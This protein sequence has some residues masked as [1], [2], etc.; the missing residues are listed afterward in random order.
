MTQSRKIV[1]EFGGVLIDSEPVLKTRNEFPVVFTDVS[2]SISPDTGAVTIEGGLG[3]QG[4]ICVGDSIIALGGI[5]MVNKTISNLGPPQDAHDAISLDFFNSNSG[6]IVAGVGITKNMNVISVSPSQLHISSLGTIRNGTWM[7]DPIQ[8]QYGG[9]GSTV[10]PNGQILFGSGINPVQTDP[11]FTFSNITKTLALGG[12]NETSGIGTGAL[13]IAGGVSVNK[14]I[15]VGGSLTV[16]GTQTISGRLVVANVTNVGEGPSGQGALDVAGGVTISGNISVEG[17]SLVKGALTLDHLLCVSTAESN[18]SLTG[19][20]VFRGGVGI[21]GQ[22]QGGSHATF[23]GRL[24]VQSIDDAALKVAGGAYFAKSLDIQG[25]IESVGNVRSETVETRAISDRSLVSAGGLYVTR[26]AEIGQDINVGQ[27]ATVSRNLKVSSTVRSN[28]IIVSSNEDEA[29][30]IAGGSVFQGIVSFSKAVTL[31]DTLI[32]IHTGDSDSASTGSVVFKGGLGIAKSIWVGANI[33]VQ[34]G[35]IIHGSTDTDATLSTVPTTADNASIRTAG[36]VTVKKSVSVGANLMVQGVISCLDVTDSPLPNLGSVLCAGGVGIAKGL[37]VGGSTLFVGASQF[38]GVVRF[39]KSVNIDGN[40]DSTSLGM[41]SLVTQGGASV[42]RSLQVGGNATINGTTNLIGVATLSNLVLAGKLTSTSLSDATAVDKAA[43]VFSGGIAVGKTLIVGGDLKV[44]GETNLTNV[45]FSGATAFPSVLRAQAPD[46]ATDATNGGLVVTGGIGVGKTL[47]VAGPGVFA[48]NVRV[49]GNMNV[50]STSDAVDLSSGCLQLDGGISVKR[51]MIIGG[52]ANVQGKLTAAQLA[53]VGGTVVSGSFSALGPFSSNGDFSSTGAISS[54]GVESDG[55]T[56]VMKVTQGKVTISGGSTTEFSNVLDSNDPGS[57]S[58]IANGGIGIAKSLNV[59]ESA[60]IHGTADVH[61]SMTSHSS[62]KVMGNILAMQSLTITGMLTA[63]NVTFTGDLQLTTG[64]AQ[65]KKILITDTSDVSGPTGASTRLLG[66]INIAKSALIGN[67]CKVMGA[68]RADTTCVLGGATRVEGIL[69]TSDLTES[70]SLS[71]AS[72]VF[73]GGLSVAKNTTLS[74]L[75]VANNAVVSGTIMI[76]NQITASHSADATGTGTGAI[77]AVGGISTAKS[78][79]AGGDLIVSGNARFLGS[80]SMASYTIITQSVTGTTDSTTAA[81]GSFTTAG[82]L[83]VAKSANIGATLTSNMLRVLSNEDASSPTS[84]AAVVSGGLSVG[85]NSYLAGSLQV[86]GTSTFSAAVSINTS[87]T[88]SG[89]VTLGNTTESTGTSVGSFLCAG[90]AGISKNMFVGGTGNFASSLCAASTGDVT[91][92]NAPAG[93]SLQVSGGAIILKSLLVGAGIT[94]PGG[95]A[96]SSLTV[97]GSASIMGTVTLN[98]TLDMALSVSGG[99]QI[100]K[101]VSVTDNVTV[102]QKITASTLVLTGT[103]DSPDTTTGVLVCGG[104]IATQ[105]SMYVGANI[106]AVGSISTKNRVIVTGDVEATSA[107]N[108]SNPALAASASIATLGG[109]AVAKSLFI[110]NVLNVGGSATF[111]NSLAVV[112]TTESDDASQGCATFAGGVGV[113]RNVSI[114]RNLT[115]V[116]TSSLRGGITTSTILATAAVTFSDVSDAVALD[117]ASVIIKGGASVVKSLKVGNNISASSANI[118]GSI[119]TSTINITDKIDGSTSTRA[120]SIVTGGGVLIGKDLTVTGTISSNG[121]ATLS[122]GLSVTGGV[123]AFSAAVKFLDSTSSQSPQSGSVTFVGGVGIGGDININGDIS[124]TSAQIRGGLTVNNGLTVKSTGKVLFQSDA[125]SQDFS[126]AAFVTVGGGSF[127]K[128]LRV[129]GDFHLTGAANLSGSLS[130]Q[131]LNIRSTT[132]SDGTASNGA[133]S[134]TGGV[135]VGKSMYVMGPLNALSTSVTTG[136]ATFLGAS[137]FAGLVTLTNATDLTALVLTGGATVTKSLKVSGTLMSNTQALLTNV[138]VSEGLSVS[139]PVTFTSNLETSALITGGVDIG[140]ALKVATNVTVGKT[141]KVGD[142]LSITS[143]TSATKGS[144][145]HVAAAT[146]TDTSTAAQ[147]SGDGAYTSYFGTPTIAMANSGVTLANVA[148]VFIAGAPVCENFAGTKK[149]ALWLGSGQLRI[150]ETVDSSELGTGAVIVS[151]G[152]SIARSSVFG[153][154]VTVAGSISSSGDIVLKAGGVLRVRALNIGSSVMEIDGAATITGTL[155]TASM[156][157]SSTSTRLSATSSLFLDNPTDSTQVGDGSLVSLGGASFTKRLFVGGDVTTAGNCKVSQTLT[158][159]V[160]RVQNTSVESIKAAGGVVCATLSVANNL[161]S[162]TVQTTGDLTSGGVV[163]VLAIAESTT[164]D[165][166][167]IQT[168]GGVG[169]KGSCY[170]G[171]NLTVAANSTF[172]GNV[173]VSSNILFSGTA[174]FGVT[175]SVKIQCL[176]D[177]SSLNSA[178]V[179]INGG[180][181]VNKTVR[182]GTDLR[183]AGKT[184]IDGLLVSKAAVCAANVQL[185]TLLDG[186]SVVIPVTVPGAILVAGTATNAVTVEFPSGAQCSD[187]QT[188][189]ISNTQAITGITVVTPGATFAPNMSFPSAL[190]AGQAIKYMFVASLSMWY[191]VA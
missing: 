160:I 168:N 116:G 50:T 100:G 42:K 36:G 47:F 11:A 87:L 119:V 14:S 182:V 151:G 104:G 73:Q 127:G 150:S 38:D 60:T 124:G 39:A 190:N 40:N 93:T 7:A 185:I 129:A 53:I 24:L 97:S 22:L 90:G 139:G 59:G 118:S 43:A 166:G 189:F 23:N 187:G 126:T 140:R 9:L 102:G 132:D 55:Y 181:S 141:L 125:E 85:R 1:R 86:Y 78:L 143:Q 159:D 71:A 101:S 171:S 177:A 91:S 146:I 183:V 174:T 32:N 25:N 83:G 54:L 33:N 35:L 130:A 155:S 46:D 82:G 45:S 158:S 148:T 120:D 94:T 69:S 105:R 80:V 21:S 56:P 108:P 61:G 89:V 157:V 188:I 4:T 18:S 191:R 186:A 144:I 99:A 95:M 113:S 72:V 41:G 63:G 114:G 92:L 34:A 134:V 20:A 128:S 37:S 15:Y 173:A 58:V 98:S 156:I 88:V 154:N 106:T 147:S 8:V 51:S 84:A 79:F 110:G 175:S 131:T 117:Q 70:T 96:S 3:V 142:T 67:E 49:S 77:S 112:S 163:R 2:E 75:L 179:V 109:L 57:G 28:K 12:L 27:D 145:L 137:I 13:T 136:T 31:R 62:L 133:L 17:N 170:I 52:A 30:V 153:G 81:N 172:Y 149:A 68:F 10:L 152:L 64:L 122:G 162:G 48:T 161:T 178:S 19:S 164:V 76:S 115:V 6:G 184:I 176:D 66:G 121:I 123:T 169:M 65:V 74:S 103:A 5:D 16:Q 167:S 135:L 44:Q 165:T 180:I 107:V 29:V 26:S 111:R 138:S